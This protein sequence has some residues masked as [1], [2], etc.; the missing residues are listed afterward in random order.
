TSPLLTHSS[1]HTSMNAFPP[2]LTYPWIQRCIQ[3]LAE[4][5]GG[6]RAVHIRTLVMHNNLG[7]LRWR[8]YAW[9]HRGAAGEIVKTG[10]FSRSHVARRQVL[11]A[12]PPPQVEASACAPSDREALA[13]ARHGRNHAYFAAIYRLHLERVAGFH[14]P[15][16]TIEVP[17]NVLNAFTF[18]TENL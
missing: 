18:T 2:M 5:P 8:P 7:D 4:L 9:W 17:L 13:L 10:F 11:L 16:G 3:T 15:H 6:G 1:P 12:Q 14:L